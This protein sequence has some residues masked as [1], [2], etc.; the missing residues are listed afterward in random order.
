MS[1]RDSDQR[2]HRLFLLVREFAERAGPAAPAIRYRTKPDEALDLTLAA[3]RALGS[4]AEWLVIQAAAGLDSPELPMPEQT[5][6]LPTRELLMA[7]KI[8]AGFSADEG[9]V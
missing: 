2:F 4:R 6:V 8:E 1:M 7:L 3:R 5:L 9:L